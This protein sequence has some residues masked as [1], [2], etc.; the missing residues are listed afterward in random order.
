MPGAVVS[1]FAPLSGPTA[2]IVDRPTSLLAASRPAQG[3]AL[4]WG[5]LSLPLRSKQ[6]L[7]CRAPVVTVHSS[8]AAT[9]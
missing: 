3:S 5:M 4:G 2:A 8:H 9:H 6:F 1:A 7:T